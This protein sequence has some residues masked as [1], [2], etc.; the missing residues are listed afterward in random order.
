MWGDPKASESQGTWNLK[1]IGPKG[2]TPLPPT[3]EP[4]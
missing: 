4:F 1:E 3:Q 2:P